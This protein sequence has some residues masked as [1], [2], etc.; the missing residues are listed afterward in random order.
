MYLS[1][2]D[3]F[4]RFEKLLSQIHSF[5]SRSTVHTAE[6]TKMQH[7]LD[8]PTL[9]LQRPTE[10]RWLSLDNS[11]TAL[12][13]SLQPVRCVLEQEAAE[14]DATAIGL[15]KLLNQLEFTLTLYLLSDILSSLTI[16]PNLSRVPHLIFLVSK[17]L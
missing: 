1:I 5:F 3:W 6:L 15:S 11:V 10:T 9:K 13:H 8:H 2:F 7:V 4:N 17:N 12:R 16:C 14:G